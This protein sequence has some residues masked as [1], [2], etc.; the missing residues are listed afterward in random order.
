MKIFEPIQIKGMT[1]KNRISMAPFANM[2]R[3]A[4]GSVNEVAIRWYEERAKGGVGLI[5]AAPFS[6]SS[7]D[8]S[9]P[10]KIT[11]RSVGTPFYDERQLAGYDK[12]AEV[13][14]SYGVK[15]G[16]QIVGGGPMAG[17]QGPSPTPY[18]DEKHPKDGIFDVL[19]MR[20]PTRELSVEEIEQHVH[21]YGV[22]AARMKTAGMDFV[23]IHATHGGASM[24]SAFMSPFYNRRTDKYGGDWEGRL[25]LPIEVI[26]EVRKAVGDDFPIF[27][28]ISADNLL[29]KRGVTIEDTTQI[30]VPALEKAGVDCFDVSM[31]SYQHSTEGIIIPMYYPR[32]HFIYCSAAVKKV[33]KL[34]VIGVGRIVDMEMANRFIEEGK[35][36]IIHMGRQLASD[37]ETPKK[38]FEGRPEDIR[39]CIG[40]VN[41]TPQGGICGRPCAINYDIQDAPIPLTKAKSPKKVLVIG[42]GV[43]GMEAARIATLRGHKV[44]LIE[45]DSELGG[46]VAALALT[47]LTGEFRNIV[48]YLAAQMRKLKVDVRVC[49]EATIADVQ[50][51]KPDVIII[52]AGSSMVIPEVAKG[53]PGVMSHIEA[54]RRQREIGQKVVIWGLVATELAISLAEEGKDVIM[55]GRG[56]EDTL[57]RYAPWERRYWLLGKLTDLNVVRETP[58]TT[59]LNNPKILYYVDVE[60][61]TAEGIK[62]VFK[63]GEKRVLPYDT[64]IISRERVANDSLF[65]QLQGK[66]AEVYKIG[67]CSEVGDIQKA[68]WGANEVARKI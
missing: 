36:D 51:L 7:Q 49:K 22:I 1:V 2:P 53:K 48:D 8:R 3:G 59:R 42:G 32:G 37:P 9:I 31:G 27:I 56:G 21:D 67:D 60:D 5:V 28:R 4:D 6:I 34:P 45:K 65:T 50:E 62:I 14:H 18:P 52:A 25:R 26:K 13:I 30:I 29:G 47:K 57:A 38:Y 39:K 58:L 17:G 20:M 44:T 40:C 66:A 10:G 63:G 16:P 15:I 12:L 24:L 68:I 23:E 19:A 33:T 46:M 35:A 11:I 54:C 64:F 43:G 41:Q 61:I 55:M